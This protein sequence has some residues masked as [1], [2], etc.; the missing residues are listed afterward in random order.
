MMQ[1]CASWNMAVVPSRQ[2]SKG[3]GHRLKIA[4]LDHKR[5]SEFVLRLKH[6]ACCLVTECNVVQKHPFNC[7]G[8]SG[9]CVLTPQRVITGCDDDQA[10][11]FNSSY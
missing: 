11:S 8:C 7:D 9:C 1:E 5:S 3:G 2:T 6:E 4:W 10:V